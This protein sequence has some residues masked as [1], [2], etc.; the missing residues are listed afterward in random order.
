MLKLESGKVDPHCYKKM[1]NANNVIQDRMLINL[2][3]CK[4]HKEIFKRLKFY[5]FGIPFANSV[6]M[7]EIMSENNRIFHKK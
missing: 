7:C 3:Y 4:S 1:L 6:R 2:F 5:I